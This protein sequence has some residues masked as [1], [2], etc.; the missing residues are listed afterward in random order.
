MEAE[1][2][3]DLPS[4]GEERIGGAYTLRNDSEE[5][6]LRQMLTPIQSEQG[7]S[8]EREEVESLEK[9]KPYLT[10]IITLPPACVA[11]VER[12]PDREWVQSERR[13]ENSG[14]RKE[15]DELRLD[16]W[17]QIKSTG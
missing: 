13:V 4:F 15:E 8:K 2:G 5:E 11:S 12:M 7:S 9:D 10:K 1:K 17:I 16:S 6:L 14:I 3:S